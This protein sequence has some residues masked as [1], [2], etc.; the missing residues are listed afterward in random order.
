MKRP[1][2]LPCLGLL[3]I[4][5]ALPLRA[6]TPIRGKVVSPDGR[7]LAGVRVELRPVLRVYDQGL[8][9]LQGLGEPEAAAR[10]VSG[11]E[12]EFLLS[13]PKM[14]IWRL[15][16]QAEGF[17]AMQSSPLPVFDDVRLDPVEMRPSR[18]WLVRIAGADGSP[19][20]GARVRALSSWPRPSQGW[21]PADRGGVSGADGTLRL[22]HAAGE[23]LRLWIL[24]PG[25]PAQEHPAA[26]DGAVAKLERGTPGRLWAARSGKAVPGAVVRE[27]GSGLLLG[28]TDERGILGFEAPKSGRWKARVEPRDARAT[29]FPVENPLHKTVSL[30]LP[31]PLAV[32]GRVVDQTTGGPVAGAWVW[33]LDDPA[34]F[35]RTDA[36]GSYRLGGLV[37]AG[38]WLLADA[39]GYFWNSFVPGPKASAP[40][41]ALV[42]S[43]TLA[44][45][46]VD[47]SGQPLEGVRIRG[48]VRGDG[49]EIEHFRASTSAQ[50]RFR[51]S[52]LGQGS[53]ELVLSRPG[54]AAARETV[55]LSSGESRADLRFVLR[56]G[57]A[58]TGLLL[59]EAGDPVA[60]AEVE[61][62]RSVT[63]APG[64]FEEESVAEDRL[65]RTATGSGGRFRIDD[66]PAGGYELNAHLRG[67]RPLAE[68]GLE[69]PREESVQDLGTF[70]LKRGAALEGRVRDP[71]GSPVA[72]AEVWVSQPGDSP[73]ILAAAEAAGPAARTRLD[74]GF[75]LQGL[76]PEQAVGLEICRRGHLTAGLLLD[77]VPAEPVEITLSPAARVA[78]RV[79]GPNGEPVPGAQVEAELER[80]PDS[81]GP[82]PSL[83]VSPC[84]LGSGSRSASTGLDGS[85]LLEALEPGR[86]R[87]SAMA[88]GY[89]PATRNGVE[90]RHGVENRTPD[91]AL[92]R[93]AV[94][95]GRVLAPDG[96]P[97]AGAA[98]RASGERTQPRGVTDGDG[99]YRLEGVE[100]GKVRAEAAHEDHGHANQETAVSPGEN[101]LDLR[102]AKR[103]GREVRGRVLAPDG[104]PVEGALIETRGDP[105]HYRTTYS[106]ADGAFVLDLSEKEIVLWAR[107]EGFSPGSAGIPAGDTAPP[108]LEIRLEPT[109]A[110]TGRLLGLS[111]EEVQQATVSAYHE[112]L[113]RQGI[114]DREG[115]FRILD[116][117]P[118]DWQL[119]A[120]LGDRKVEV[121]I[122]VAPGE[123]VEVD[124]TLP[125]Q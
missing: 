25:Y 110:I 90:V 125:P 104:E 44:G 31:S 107:K 42:P 39:T 28:Q 80:E 19:L 118:G 35:A 79:V 75:R 93:G 15:L 5:S 74:G 72:D 86:F 36:A 116:V 46:V 8:R 48:L 18:G 69:L 108:P 50:G 32:Q 64:D 78:G 21:L 81:S 4:L 124:L 9:E 111:A 45:I 56:P 68:K 96:T 109:A 33:T 112:F 12:G 102:L 41:L 113:E 52:R 23:T 115:G 27:A 59:D 57:R 38:T 82:F 91:L 120:R 54:F 34:A 88:A 99:N 85:F 76:D 106:G 37:P 24:A 6:Q 100:P 95:F 10:T 1:L 70:V 17:V 7:G 105:F 61:L 83:S 26:V 29:V 121:R 98:V 63:A 73:R 119:E 47:E 53:F 123:A 77:S 71:S 3:A 97:V 62:V 84:P 101:H 87:V 92:Q 66:L 103:Q 55:S 14:G 22:S 117:A 51:V 122:S 2:L 114:V 94:L 13:T 89:L 65:F 58:A 40:T 49:E 20:A 67:F 11:A 60:G 30:A 16:L 43:G